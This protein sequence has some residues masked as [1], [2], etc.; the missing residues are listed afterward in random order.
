MAQ[1][2]TRVERREQTRAELLAAA[3]R[4][5]LRDGFHAA[6]LE[7]ISEEAGYTRGA[8]YSNFTSKDDVFLAVLDAELSKRVRPYAE[9][10]VEHLSFEEALR[11]IG[12]HFAALEPE[13]RPVVIEFQMRAL[14]NELLRLALRA[15][16]DRL[17]DAI[18]AVIEQL[19]ARHGIGTLIPPREIARATRALGRGLTLERLLDPEAAPETLMEDLFMKLTLALVEVPG[20]AQDRKGSK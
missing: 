16:Q 9:L 18:A 10:A 8:V 15:Q 13:W 2:L 3:R 4:V 19:T 1:R 14:R 17:L 6:S 12:R 20:R 5:F 7:Q 11:A